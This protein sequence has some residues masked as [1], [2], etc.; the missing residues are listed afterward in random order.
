MVGPGTPNYI[1]AYLSVTPTAIEIGN[2]AS[3]LNKP[4][5]LDFHPILSN[6]EL[7]VINKRNENIGG[8]TTTF[9]NAG[10]KQT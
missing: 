7:W 9:W 5:D 4:T 6:S 8:S 10:K 2:A 3:G 1:D